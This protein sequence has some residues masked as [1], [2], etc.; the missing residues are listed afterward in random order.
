LRKSEADRFHRGPDYCQRTV[1]RVHE[2]TK[3]LLVE[4]HLA[5]GQGYSA[6]AIA[7]SDIRDDGEVLE[8][9]LPPTY[10]AMKKADLE[11]ALSRLNWRRRIVITGGRQ[12]KHSHPSPAVNPESRPPI[13]QAD[14]DAA[15]AKSR[16]KI[17]PQMETGCGL[18][19]ASAG[20]FQ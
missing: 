10:F 11:E 17:P 19:T 6:D 14:V 1:E 9:C 2:S 5:V 3:S 20:G 8:I 18:T 12:V 13:T 4:A 16:Q 7:D 15:V